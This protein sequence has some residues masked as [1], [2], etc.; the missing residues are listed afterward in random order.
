[1]SV[2]KCTAC[3][4]SLQ[5]VQPRQYLE[6]E[7]NGQCRQQASHHHCQQEQRQHDR[8]R[9]VEERDRGYEGDRHSSQQ[10]GI[11]IGL[12][13]LSCAADHTL[14]QDL[15]KVWICVKTL[16]GKCDGLS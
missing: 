1:M 3:T 5:C 11:G 13:P 7:E 8:L 15:H 14:V 16:E 4:A 12:S 10:R 6:E 9:D 2:P